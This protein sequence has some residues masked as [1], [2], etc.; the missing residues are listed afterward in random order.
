MDIANKTKEE[1]V[2]KIHDLED[3]IARKGIGARYVQKVE[4]AQ[5]NV[6]LALL[7]GGM[8]TVVGLAAYILS[9]SDDDE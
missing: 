9:G 4:K 5:R 7:L 1:L 8:L 3:L 2:N 6:N